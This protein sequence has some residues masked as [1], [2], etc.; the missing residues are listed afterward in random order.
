MD[1]K[2]NAI[3]PSIML[4]SKKTVRESMKLIVLE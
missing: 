3:K 2:I 1:S 4:V